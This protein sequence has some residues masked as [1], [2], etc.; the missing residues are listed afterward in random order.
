MRRALWILGSLALVAVLVIGI[1]QA[2]GDDGASTRAK[3]DVEDPGGIRE[4]DVQA[5]EEA[6]ADAKGKP[7]VVNAWASWCGPCKLEMPIFA[8]VAVD[9]ADDVV[10]LGL[11]VSDNREEAERFLAKEPVPY[12]SLEDGDARIVQKAG[13]TGGLPATIF[14]DRAGKR[15]YIHQGQYDSEQDLLDDIR[16]YT[17][18]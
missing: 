6:I 15:A 1:V 7:V 2:G 17:G 8:K 5:Y 10:F 11:N 18:A 3:A 4:A 13:G 16:R 9:R 14:Y 12:D